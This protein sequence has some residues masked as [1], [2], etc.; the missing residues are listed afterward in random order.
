MASVVYNRFY[1]ELAIGNINLS[2]DSIYCALAS[3]G[4]TPDADHDIW[5]TGQSGPATNEISGTGYT[6]GGAALSG[7]AVTES[8]AN[9]N[10]KW[11]ANNVTW[12]GSTITARHA[13][14]YDQTTTSNVLIACFDFAADKSSNAGDFVVQWSA[15]GILTLSTA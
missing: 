9:N 12:S 14:L 5:S 11:D 8:D 1:R 6:A 3:S 4:Y 2:T 10:A 7:K 15:A 13:V